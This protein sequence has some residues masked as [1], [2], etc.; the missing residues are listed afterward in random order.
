MN[1]VLRIYIY[2]YSFKCVFSCMKLTN[3]SITLIILTVI[4]LHHHFCVLGFVVVL[5]TCTFCLLFLGATNTY[6]VA[7]G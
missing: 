5:C 3:Y 4:F 1:S 6:I 2:Y 7:F